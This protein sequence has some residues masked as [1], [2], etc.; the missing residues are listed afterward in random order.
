MHFL[1]SKQVI[2][3]EYIYY[4]FIYFNCYFAQESPF[5]TVCKNKA[6]ITADK[7]K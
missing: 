1:V 4:Y 6:L 5:L 2:S 7:V 3:Y